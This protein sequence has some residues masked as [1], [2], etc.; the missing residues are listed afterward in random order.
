MPIKV[1]GPGNSHTAT[2]LVG[3]TNQHQTASAAGGGDHPPDGS[4]F[5]GDYNFRAHELSEQPEWEFIGENRCDHHKDASIICKMQESPTRYTSYGM[6][7]FAKNAL[8]CATRG[9]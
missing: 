3:T 8:K 2:E 7:I 5:S 9:G 1:H 6:H 4:P